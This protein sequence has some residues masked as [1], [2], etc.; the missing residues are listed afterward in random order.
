MWRDGNENSCKSYSDAFLCMPNGD[1]G[2]GWVREHPTYGWEEG[3][4]PKKFTD[5]PDAQGRTATSACCAC[6]GGSKPRKAP[7][8]GDDKE[9]AKKDRTFEACKSHVP[10]P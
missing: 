7:A 4:V 3:E 8:A 2:P 6:G 1:K 9:Q 10:A 5:F